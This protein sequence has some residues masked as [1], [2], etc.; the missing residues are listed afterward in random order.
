VAAV[1]PYR[2]RNALDAVSL[3]KASDCAGSGGVVGQAHLNGVVVITASRA[4]LRPRSSEFVT[5]RSASVMTQPSRSPGCACIGYE[6]KIR[7]PYQRAAR[8]ASKSSSHSS[9]KSHCM[10]RAKTCD[11]CSAPQQRPPA[12]VIG[13]FPSGNRVV[14]L[15]LSGGTCSRG[16]RDAGALTAPSR[17]SR[18]V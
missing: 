1:S 18:V 7:A 14:T 17:A 6:L 12:L 2:A 13:S 9:P 15:V 10:C 16:T 8:L 11:S 3:V 4:L 5:L